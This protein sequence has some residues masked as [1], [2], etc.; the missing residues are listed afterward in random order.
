MPNYRLLS[1]HGTMLY[2]DTEAGCLRHGSPDTVPEN[3]VLDSLIL[4]DRCRLLYIDPLTLI[5]SQLDDLN[6]ADG[7]FSL[8]SD[9]PQFNLQLHNISQDLIAISENTNY[10]SSDLDGFVRMNRSWCREWEHYR[11]LP[12]EIAR[13]EQ[14]DTPTAPHG[15]RGG[16]AARFVCLSANEGKKMMAN[17]QNESSSLGSALDY[18]QQLLQQTTAGDSVDPEIF[19]ELSQV[20]AEIAGSLRTRI[21]E[22]SAKISFIS[23][24]VSELFPELTVTSAAGITQLTDEGLD[25]AS[26]AVQAAMEAKQLLAESEARVRAALDKHDYDSLDEHARRARE[27]DAAVS[28]QRELLTAL[29]APPSDRDEG[30]RA[31]LDLSPPLPSEPGSAPLVGR[32][33]G[34]DVDRES[35]DLP[36]IEYEPPSVAEGQVEEAPEPDRASAQAPVPEPGHISN[37][38]LP[39]GPRTLTAEERVSAETSVAIPIPDDTTPDTISEQNATQGE[40]LSRTA[41]T[42]SS[43]APGPLSTNDPDPAF[44]SAL[45]RRLATIAGTDGK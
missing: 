11:L 5:T 30:V 43:G 12:V 24:Q 37:V 6:N 42:H 28:A 23:A 17:H 31:D 10:L 13:A 35:D 15:A 16:A 21:A 3:L 14:P 32:S 1:H 27:H 19:D 38:L 4:A 25:R 29:L 45:R 18:F 22:R 2:F 40:P 9:H 34:T 39:G 41:L 36:P 20:A 7:Y 8:K 26:A 44:W 33:E